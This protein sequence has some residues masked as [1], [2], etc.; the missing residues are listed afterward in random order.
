MFRAYYFYKSA[1]C[2]GNHPHPLKSRTAGEMAQ[3]PAYHIMAKDK[4]MPWPQLFD[5]KAA[6]A[7]NWNPITTGFGI[8]GIPTMFLIDKKGVC[9]TIEAR[10]KMEDLIPKLLAE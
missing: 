10:E 9:R 6:E 4:D 3:M 8:E 2:K 5:P 7:Q 1:D